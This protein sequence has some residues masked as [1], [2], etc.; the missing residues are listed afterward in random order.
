MPTGMPTSTPTSVSDM[1][2]HCLVLDEWLQ[3]SRQNDYLLDLLCLDSHINTNDNTHEHPNF[4]TYLRKFFRVDFPRASTL[5]LMVSYSHWLTLF[6]IVLFIICPESHGNAHWHAYFNA[7][8]GECYS[9]IFLEIAE[10]S[11]C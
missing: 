8:L 7:Y 10:D 4:Y 9:V 1:C 3:Y 6:I 5:Y 11:D 2:A